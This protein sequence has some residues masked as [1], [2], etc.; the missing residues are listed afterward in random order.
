MANIYG[1]LGIADGERVMLQSI[2]Q[3]V[4]FDAANEYLAS[5]NTEIGAA[6]GVFV[7]QTTSDY[8]WRYKLPGG[9]MLQRRGGQAES[10]AV[11]PFGQWDVAFPLEEFGV[12][13]AWTDVSFAYMTTQDLA[14]TMDSV[15][16]QDLN[17]LRYEMLRALFNSTARTFTDENY[18]SLSIQPLANGD[19]VTYPPVLGSQSE[20]TE[21][22]YLES[23]YA[24][25]SIS[26]TNDP[27]VTV[28]NEL[29]EHF[30]APS[31]G[32]NI[33]T[34]VNNAH[35]GQLSALTDFVEVTDRFVT[36]GNQT[37]VPSTLPQGLP[38]RIVGRHNAGAWIV[39]WRQ[40]PAN[41]VLGIDLDQEGPLVMR[42]DPADT[43]LAPGL[44]L[45]STNQNYP[46]QQSHFRRRFGVGVGNRLNG[47][48]IELGT[49]GSYT[50]PSGF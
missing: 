48:V 6:L 41:Y 21:N 28:V 25:A 14:R 9:G 47:V 43:G 2:G 8:K 7:G 26:N 17:V 18:G 13:V 1:I 33:V 31:G 40:M 35:V 34:F 50:V 44:Q 46:F 24:A 37:A 29:Q 39:E 3:R 19:A 32:G 4:V 42:Q 5:Y 36:P 23:N 45:V 38:G 10:A 16:I 22:H 49:G 15:R 12:Q 11:K 27:V 20:A 30:G